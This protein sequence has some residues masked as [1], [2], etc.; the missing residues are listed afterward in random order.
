[1]TLRVCHIVIIREGKAE[2]FRYGHDGKQVLPLIIGGP[3]YV[4]ASRILNTLGWRKVEALED[5]R[6]TACVDF[7]RKLL[8][9][10]GDFGVVRCERKDL[11]YETDLENAFAPYWSGWRYVFRLGFAVDYLLEHAR[12]HGLVLPTNRPPEAE[13]RFAE[14]TEDN[15]P[16]EHLLWERDWRARGAVSPPPARLSEEHREALLTRLESLDIS[17]AAIRDHYIFVGDVVAATASEMD[18]LGVDLESRLYLLRRFEDALGLDLSGPI[19]AFLIRGLQEARG[20]SLPVALPAEW[21][22]WRR[23][24]LG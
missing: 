14:S 17:L 13:Q 21:P 5:A 23:Q 24:A 16:M 1:M 20:W 3:E 12:S 8:L 6:S 7:D 9:L 11:L 10:G 19:P 22:E 18:V 2:I 4:N 15:D